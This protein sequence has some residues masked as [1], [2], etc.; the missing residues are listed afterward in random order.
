MAMLSTSI[1]PLG[2]EKGSMRRL[3]GA[4]LRWRYWV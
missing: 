1:A 4:A 2:A 3:V